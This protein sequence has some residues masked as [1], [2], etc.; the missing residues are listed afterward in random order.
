[1]TINN[2][3]A[4]LKAIRSFRENGFEISYKGAED[5]K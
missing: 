4:V 5:K 2:I 3:I 1:M